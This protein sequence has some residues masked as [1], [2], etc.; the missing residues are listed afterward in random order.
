M[1]INMIQVNIEKMGNV[2]IIELAGELDSTSASQIQEQVLSVAGD[3]GRILLDMS[4][5]TYMSSAG[6]R[7]LLLM[8]RRINES[9]NVG[10]IVLAGLND[11]LQDIM[12]ITG[13]LDF[14][15]TVEDRNA[16]LRVWN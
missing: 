4:K 12:A 14:F 2:T 11:E 3:G 1:D 5:V 13:F 9:E 15:T 6:L 10:E 7:I 8:Y 16:A